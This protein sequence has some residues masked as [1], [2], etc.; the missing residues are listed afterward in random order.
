MKEYREVH[1]T[2]L[3]HLLEEASLSNLESSSPMLLSQLITTTIIKITTTTIIT[4]TTKTII[5]IT[6]TTTI[7]KIIIIKVENH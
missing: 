7:V 2:T 6:T 3:K 4:I 1:C 5:T